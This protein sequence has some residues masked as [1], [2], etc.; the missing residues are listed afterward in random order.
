MPRPRDNVQPKHQ[1][2]WNKAIDSVAS[3]NGQGAVFT[4]KALAKNGCAPAL[5]QIGRIYEFGLG[6]I[7]QDFKEAVKWFKLSIEAIDDLQSHLALARIYLQ[8][9]KLDANHKLALYHLD[10]LAENEVAGAYFGLGL[11]HEFGLGV[12]TDESLALD[13]YERAQLLGHLMARLHGN[14]IRFAEKPIRYFLPLIVTS[15]QVRYAKLRN[16][17][18]QRLAM[19]DDNKDTITIP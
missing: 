12:P 2:Q 4:C 16:P 5:G 18:D 8:N 3:G 15:L 1:D 9:P 6:G 7:R 11:V 17:Y 19:W 10:L 13:W 14:R